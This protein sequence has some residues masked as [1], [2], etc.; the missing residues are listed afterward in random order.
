MTINKYLEIRDGYNYFPE[1]NLVQFHVNSP[2]KKKDYCRDN[3][4]SPLI[5]T[6]QTI[7]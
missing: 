2:T 1:V 6:G 5:G 7:I 3:K 4:Q